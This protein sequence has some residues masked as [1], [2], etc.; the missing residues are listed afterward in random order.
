MV[1]E[2]LRSDGKKINMSMALMV[3]SE[4]KEIFE[5]SEVIIKD[6]ETIHSLALSYIV[7]NN[8]PS[9]VLKLLVN[10]SE[11]NPLCTIRITKE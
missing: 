9:K 5:N 6:N 11:L 8:E 3:T 1:L 10:I 4:V 7:P 2:V